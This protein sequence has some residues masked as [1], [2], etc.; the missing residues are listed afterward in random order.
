MGCTVELV[1][2]RMQVIVQDQILDSL[3]FFALGRL[4]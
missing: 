1:A 3:L 2:F 4:L